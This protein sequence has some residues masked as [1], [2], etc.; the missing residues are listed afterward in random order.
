[1]TEKKCN[2][3]VPDIC[4]EHSEEIK[5]GNLFLKS[6]GG[7]D[8]FCGEIRT[9]QCEHSNSIVKE[10]VNE[11]GTGKVLFI[12]HTGSEL[13]SM[14][15]DQIAQQAYENNWNGILV[16][17]F[18]RDI[19][20]IKEI[21]IGVYAK[22]SYPMKTDKLVGVG[23]KNVNFNIDNLEINIGEWVYVDQNGFVI[24]KKELVL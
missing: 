9:A 18:I 10:M 24:S 15:G 19:E 22:N 14:V 20:F 2:F 8:K 1:M 7:L 21:P 6:Y 3:T 11:D 13:C 23:E 16:N 4:D 17:G 12:N 5:I